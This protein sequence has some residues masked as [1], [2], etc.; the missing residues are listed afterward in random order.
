MRTLWNKAKRIGALAL[1]AAMLAGTLAMPVYAAYDPTYLADWEAVW[2]SDGDKTQS[3]LNMI[4]KY[5]NGTDAYFWYVNEYYSNWWNGYAEYQPEMFPE[6][7]GYLNKLISLDDITDNPYTARWDD[8]PDGYWVDPDGYERNYTLDAVSQK[9]D[10]EMWTQGH[11]EQTANAEQE[12]L[13]QW[14]RDVR[15]E[16]TDRAQTLAKE[17]QFFLSRGYTAEEAAE[18]A[19]EDLAEA[20]TAL[21]Q[22]IPAYRKELE[23]IRSWYNNGQNSFKVGVYSDTE[24]QGS[25]SVNGGMWDTAL[26]LYTNTGSIRISTSKQIRGIQRKLNSM[27]IFVPKGTSVTTEATSGRSYGEGFMIWKEDYTAKTGPGI[28]AESYGRYNGDCY[29]IFVVGV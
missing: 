1:A 13:D 22:T 28:I 14:D 6:L 29:Q 20:E 8:G 7:I 17:K 16:V 12:Y 25:L 5:P 21:N 27:T 10:F 9:A 15:A 4:Q 3:Y 24:G 19:Q 2:N 26:N 23:A 11:Q 18:Y